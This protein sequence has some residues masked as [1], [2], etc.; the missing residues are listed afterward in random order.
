MHG[1]LNISIVLYRTP[2]SEWQP[3]VQELLRSRLVHGIYLVD[4][5]PE[6]MAVRSWEEANRSTGD[7]WSGLPTH[8]IHY[9]FT[10]GNL[11]Y[12]K[13][14][15]IAIRESIY[16]EVPFHLVINSD[17][18]VSATA[19]ENLVGVMQSNDL[20]GQLLPR[21]VDT[22]GELQYLC[23][24][25][26]SPIDLMRRLVPGKLGRDSL[27]NARFELR[28]V[29]HSRPINAPYLSGCFMLLRTEALIK[30]GLFDERFFM[31]PEDIDLTRRIHREYLTLYYPSETIVHAHR[32][33]SYHSMRMLW[34]HATNMLRYF[35]K[36][37]WISDSER[38][39]LNRQTLTRYPIAN[40]E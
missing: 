12:G 38:R 9:I 3:L 15:N 36:W 2:Q 23:K 35:R 37:G 18:Q 14:H 40:N 29:D 28:H 26:P 39:Q 1:L 13:A 27:R 5:S 33:A 20:I 10:D 30:C 6:Q 7:S 4:N 11:G 8:K 34:V 16:D 31:Y 22:N 17:I 19:I 32:R 25:L 24:L 21:V